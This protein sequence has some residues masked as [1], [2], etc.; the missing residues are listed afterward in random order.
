MVDD[1]DIQRGT[2]GE[3][4]WN[5]EDPVIVMESG[6]IVAWN[7]AAEITF[8]IPAPRALAPGFDLGSVFGGGTRLFLDLASSGGRALIEC[9][10]GCELDLEVTAWKA[11]SDDEPPRVAV[12]RDVTSE[13]RY[14]AGFRRLTSVAREVL[15]EGSFEVVLQRI[16]DE[17]KELTQAAFSALLLLRDESVTEIE[18][19]VFNAPRHRFP[20]RLPRVV[21][22]LGEAIE[23]R[24]PV[25]IEDIRGH[26][27]GVGIPVGYPPIA[28]ILAV[29]VTA[30]DVTLGELVVAAPPGGKVFDDVDEDVLEEL[31]ANAAAAHRL[32]KA[33]L[34]KAQADE[35]AR[36]L[37]DVARH[38][39]K[40]PVAVAKASLQLLRDRW[41]R[42]DPPNR[43]LLME[44]VDN[45]LD[46]VVRLANQLLID[47]RLQASSS[48]G[49]GASVETGPLLAGLEEE[50]APLARERNITLS[51]EILPG[52]P[53]SF[54]GSPSLVGHAL[55][56]MITNAIK[57]S[58]RDG[59]VTVT[60]R[61]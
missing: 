57:Y 24:A 52:A 55:E 60:A 49:S 36:T 11:G 56:N 45:A 37:L 26:P 10:G 30:G 22:L 20:E 48:I 13:R 39:I 18:T 31:A 2:L 42:L 40:T 7:P 23:S 61:E 14:R 46:R 1:V 8:G 25:R 35:A 15:A 59:R 27:R 50:V 53:G 38:D 43:E 4:F 16:V 47:E 33:R 12:L 9:R 58:P 21:G 19:F 54:P 29:P 28:A 3:L 32:W 34:A 6:S 5:I 51:F 17:S 41:A 44:G